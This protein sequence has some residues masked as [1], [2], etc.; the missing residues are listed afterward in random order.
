MGLLCS[1]VGFLFDDGIRVI[2]GFDN[3]LD[4]LEFACTIAK[5]RD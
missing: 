3:A 5:A 2:L 4:A 1:V